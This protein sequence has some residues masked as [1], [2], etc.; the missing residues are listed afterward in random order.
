LARRGHKVVM[1]EAWPQPGGVLRYGIPNFKQNK[2]A[3]DRKFADLEALGVE[4][5][6]NTRVGRDL[7]WEAL[8]D[9]ADA[10]FVG[11]GASEGARLGIPNEDAPGVIPAT[12]FLV[13]T[14]L[15][16]EALPADL[17]EPVGTPR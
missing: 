3:V 11:I 2:P 12:E 9:S 15:P 17:Q 7:S 1:Y 16:P 4:V 13:R 5:R 6:C 8:H 14:N 10:V